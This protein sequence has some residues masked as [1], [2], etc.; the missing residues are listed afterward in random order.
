M[1]GACRTAGR[2]RSRHTAQWVAFL[3]IAG[4]A[5]AAASAHAGYPSGPE[6]TDRDAPGQISLKLEDWASVPKSGTSSTAQ[7]ARINFVRAEPGGPKVGTRFFA[8]DLNG[9]LYIL[10]RATPTFVTYLDFPS[11]FNGSGGT[12]IFD[13]SPGFAAGLVTFQFD[14][15]YAAN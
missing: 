2:S 8:N 10:D 13:N 4:L 9:K 15:D 6:I 14:P 3:S 1:I 11:L 7:V 5:G 12:G